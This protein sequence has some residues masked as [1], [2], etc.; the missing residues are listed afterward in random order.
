MKINP[1]Y[2]PHNDDGSDRYIVVECDIQDI[3]VI[4]DKGAHARQVARHFLRGRPA[5][6]YLFE[7]A[8]WM[9]ALKADIVVGPNLTYEEQRCLEWPTTATRRKPFHNDNLSDMCL[10][11]VQSFDE[12][13]GWVELSELLNQWPPAGCDRY[14]PEHLET[15]RRHFSNRHWA[16]QALTVLTL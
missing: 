11:A 6:T 10:R 15:V 12:F 13:D 2:R 3:A 9:G 16:C 8:D 4:A 7:K 1:S 5:L 14:H